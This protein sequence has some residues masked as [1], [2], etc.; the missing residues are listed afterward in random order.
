[1]NVKGV[2]EEMYF[3]EADEAVAEIEN[4]PISVRI[5]ADLLFLLQAM[6]ERFASTTRATLGGDLL[7][8]AIQD[9]FAQLADADLEK[10]GAAADKAYFEWAKSKYDNFQASGATYE[11]MGQCIREGREKSRNEEGGE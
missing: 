7:E 5:R 11:L 3:R 9:A 4:Q 1:M 6:A 2:M 10:V 8:A